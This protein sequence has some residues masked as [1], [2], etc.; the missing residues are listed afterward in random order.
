MRRLPHP[1]PPHLKNMGRFYPVSTEVE[2]RR[3][4]GQWTLKQGGKL[5]VCWPAYEAPARTVDLGRE[6]PEVIAPLVLRQIVEVWEAKQKA[7]R[8]K[9]SPR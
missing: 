3:Y 5:C 4:F 8:D 6:R 1:I 9:V 7:W 2:G